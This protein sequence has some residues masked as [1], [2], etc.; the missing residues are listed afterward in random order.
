MLAA[1]GAYSSAP[2]MGRL[3][4]AKGPRIPLTTALVLLFIGYF[5]IKAIFDAGSGESISLTTLSVLILCKY[6]TGI[7]G[8]SGLVGSVNTVAKSFPDKLVSYGFSTFEKH[9]SKPIANHDYGNRHIR[10][11]IVSFPI[12]HH[13]PRCIPRKHV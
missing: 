3:V 5:G 10:L 11:R 12:L 6:L 4:D 1:V 13:R 9:L 7:G 8:N 2:L